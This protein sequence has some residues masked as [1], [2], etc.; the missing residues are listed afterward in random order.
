MDLVSEINVY[1]IIILLSDTFSK[2]ELNFK[3]SE[4]DYRTMSHGISKYINL[5][6]ST[7]IFGIVLVQPQFN[8]SRL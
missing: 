8:T 6:I 2:A 5:I 7:T 3:L 1:I 4:T